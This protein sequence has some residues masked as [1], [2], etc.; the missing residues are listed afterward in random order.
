MISEESYDSGHSQ[1]NGLSR[2]TVA[3]ALSN[4]NVSPETRQAVVQK[5]CQ[6]GY[7]KLDDALV[8]EVMHQKRKSRRRDNTCIVQPLAVPVL[9]YHTGRHS[10][11]AKQ[12][13]YRMQLYIVNEDDLDGEEV[14]EQ[15]EDDVQGII[16][17]CIFPI[18]FVK[19]I[20]RAG[21]PMTFFN[22]PV[23]AQEYIALGDVYNLEGFYSMNRLTGYCIDVKKC[24]KL[25]IYWICRRL[26]SCTGK[27]AW[28]YE[29]L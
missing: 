16:F 19:G 27:I 7:A 23:D 2:N 17:L 14:L 9:E 24:T 21:L 13:G 12:E 29:R 20:A 6:M 15:L 3:K 28:I 18:R 11:G 22:T 26:Q 4:G 25:C 1:R 10:D 8:E 5:A